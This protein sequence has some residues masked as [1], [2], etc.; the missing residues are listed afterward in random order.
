MRILRLVGALVALILVA[1]MTSGVTTTSANAAPA[2]RPH[3]VKKLKAGEIRDSGRFFVRGK[4]V[5]Y[6]NKVVK[7]QKSQSRN[8]RYRPFKGDRAS[9]RT[10]V[11]RITFDG[12]V[13]TCYRVFIP[14]T[15]RFKAYKQF[16]GCIVRQ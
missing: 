13:G 11:F 2:K 16:V 3:V 5:T 1:T 9:K 10:G 8:G 4:A 15:R 7:L 6:K 12:P 14:S